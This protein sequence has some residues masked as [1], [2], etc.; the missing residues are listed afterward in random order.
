VD[1]PVGVVPRP[2]AHRI[3]A[4]GGS[5]ERGETSEEEIPCRDQHPPR[6]GA[7]H[8]RGLHDLHAVPRQED[9]G[10]DRGLHL[11]RLGRVPEPHQDADRAAGVLDPRGGDRAHGRCRLVGRVFAKA[12]GWFITPRWCR[13]CWASSSRTSCSPATTSGLPLPGHRLVGEPRHGEV[14]AQGFRE[15]PGAQVL[16]GGHGQQRDPADRGVLDVL[17]RGARLARARRRR[18]WCTPSTSSPMRC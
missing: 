16:R 3:A 2:V 4:V 10:A 12:I 5:H 15:P 7:R 6:H 8:R 9:R 14:H 17:R 18:R 1:A 11:D 13:C